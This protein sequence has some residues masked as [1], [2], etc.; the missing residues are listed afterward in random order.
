MGVQQ[1]EATWYPPVHLAGAWLL[2][3]LYRTYCYGIAGG[4]LEVQPR[5]C[6]CWD[7]ALGHRQGL[8]LK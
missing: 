8:L 5:S 7:V 3:R 4:P 1:S 6:S 2:A